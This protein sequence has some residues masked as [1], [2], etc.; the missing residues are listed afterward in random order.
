MG[1][2]ADLGIDTTRGSV[3]LIEPPD[4]VLAEASAMKPR[5]TIASSFMHAEPARWIVWWPAREDLEPGRLE[6]LHWFLSSG[7][8]GSE[9]WIVA[10]DEDE[11]VDGHE[12]RGALRGS[13]LGAGEERQLASGGSAVSVRAAI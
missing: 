3:M 1:T 10:E 9:G 2:L 6:R 5:P 8:G 12:I 13:K 7:A 11:G 4:D